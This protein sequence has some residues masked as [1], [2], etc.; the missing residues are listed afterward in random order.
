V[1][2]GTLDG[3]SLAAAASRSIGTPWLRTPFEDLVFEYTLGDNST[4]FGVVQYSGTAP[5]RSDLNGDGQINVADWTIFIANGYT[6]LSTETAVGAYRRGDL[7]GDRDNDIFDYRLF[8]A[9]YVA[10]NGA[11]AFAA[12]EAA[13]PEPA[14]IALL[15]VG[16]LWA[17]RSRTA[18]RRRLADWE[19][20]Q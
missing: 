18:R 5:I 20:I 12:L 1:T 16:L 3:G 9:D 11:G 4:G 6:N 7:D 10:A 19:S 14:T 8:K 17:C 13:V 15:A 2:G